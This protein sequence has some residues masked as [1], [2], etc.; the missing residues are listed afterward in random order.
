MV[1]RVYEPLEHHAFEHALFHVAMAALGLLSGLGATRLGLVSGRLM[2]I[3]SI[4]MPLMF[5][6][7]MT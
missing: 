5:A 7:A 3:L 1:P 2:F 6:A 4:G